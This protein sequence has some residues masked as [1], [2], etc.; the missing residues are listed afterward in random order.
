VSE[1]LPGSA[2]ELY[3]LFEKNKGDTGIE[4]ELFHPCDFRVTI[5]SSDF[6]K[7]RS[8]PELIREIESICGA[9]SVKVWN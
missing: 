3:S 6:V 1:L 5:H 9:G 4:V 2:G 7:V 8:S